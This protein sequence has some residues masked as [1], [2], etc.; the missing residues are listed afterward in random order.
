[1][2]V[3]ISP[4][5]SLYNIVVFPAASSPTEKE[6]TKILHENLQNHTF[7]SIKPIRDTEIHTHSQVHVNRKFKQ[8]S[9]K[10]E[11]IK[12]SCNSGTTHIQGME[13]IRVNNQ[14]V[15]VSNTIIYSVVDQARLESSDQ[16]LD[17]SKY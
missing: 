11:K 3:T 2:V 15:L 5:L 7:N 13:T 6:T 14:R 17:R 1:M 16:L 4:N 8:R 10:E 9:Q 12:T